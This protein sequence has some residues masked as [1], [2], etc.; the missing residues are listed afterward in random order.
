M[1]MTKVDSMAA[2]VVQELEAY[3]D[4]VM[5]G[6]KKAVKTAA[7]EC[8]DEIR[9]E[10]QRIPY[11][12]T[13]DYKKGWTDRVAFENWEDI[14]AE[15]YNRTDGQLAHLLENGHAIKNGTGRTGGSVRGRPHIRAAEDHALERLE[16]KLREAVK[17]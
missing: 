1:K 14:R 3:S 13:G 4:E 8:R 12:L 16:E 5:E 9:Q 2:A 11:V 17:G 10:V 7:R 6:V 15:V